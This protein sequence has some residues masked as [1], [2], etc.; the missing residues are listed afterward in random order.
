MDCRSLRD[1]HEDLACECHKIL[2]QMK[3][4]WSCRPLVACRWLRAQSG[5]FRII[6][7]QGGSAEVLSVRQDDF[8]E[9]HAF[10]E[11]SQRMLLDAFEQALA[12][13]RTKWAVV[14]P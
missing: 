13:T 6:D 9:A 12:S 14:E 1:R 5:I 3:R 4:A 10:V 2:R 7:V 8:D 11:P